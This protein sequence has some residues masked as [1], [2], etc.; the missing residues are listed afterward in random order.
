MEVKQ[1]ITGGKL[2]GSYLSSW[3]NELQLTVEGG[4]E[5]NVKFDESELRDLANRL[6][7]RVEAIDKEREEERQAE[8]E[9]ALLEKEEANYDD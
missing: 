8:V 2:T 5:I 4:H 9:K 1:V 3:N 6:N 7:E